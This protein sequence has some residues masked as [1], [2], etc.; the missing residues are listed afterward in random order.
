MK[1]KKA[2][3]T[4][5]VDGAEHEGREPRARRREK[6]CRGN[7]RKRDRGKPIKAKDTRKPKSSRCNRNKGIKRTC[8]GS[9]C[10]SVFI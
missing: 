2:E 4:I 1:K 5:G 6:E 8:R 9:F 10:V 3:M 7:D